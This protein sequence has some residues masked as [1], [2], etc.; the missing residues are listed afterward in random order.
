MASGMP[1]RMLR[2][3]YHQCGRRSSASVSPSWIRLLG[4]AMS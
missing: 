1:V 2:E 3:K 4:Y